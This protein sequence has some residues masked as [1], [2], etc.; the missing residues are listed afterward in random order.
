MNTNDQVIE[1]NSSTTN[2]VTTEDINF[3]QVVKAMKVESEVPSVVLEALEKEEKEKTL[4][5][6]ES[7]E[8]AM[9]AD[10]QEMRLKS[11]AYQ[12]RPRPPLTPERVNEILRRK[13]E[14]SPRDRIQARLCQKNGFV[15]PA[16]VAAYL[17]AKEKRE[18]KNAKRA[19]TR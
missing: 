8:Y 16:D 17:A 7:P 12:R 1:K 5:V 10:E 9:S 6:W 14:A 13:D 2:V 3:D 11:T 15:Q 18:R 4:V 19:R